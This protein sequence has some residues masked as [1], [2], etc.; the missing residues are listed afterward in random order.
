MHRP[1]NETTPEIDGTAPVGPAERSS[2][3][4]LLVELDRR[5]ASYTAAADAREIASQVFSAAYALNDAIRRAEKCGMATEEIRSHVAHTWRIVGSSSF[6]R[7]IQEWPRGY[8]GD[9]EAVNAIVDRRE[10]APEH[11]VAGVIGRYFL[12]CPLTQQ[13]REKLVVQALRAVE[14]CRRKAGARILSLGCGPS[15]DLDSIQHDLSESQAEIV[16]VDFDRDALEESRRRLRGLRRQPTLIHASV[17]R[18]PTLLGDLT[19][20]SGFD[21][22]YAGGLFDYLSA[23]VIAILLDK[24]TGRLLAPE[25]SFLFTN[26][27]AENPYRPWIETIANWRL[28]ERTERDLVSLIAQ[29]QLGCSG[30]RIA[31]DPTGLTWIAEVFR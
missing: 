19:G 24:I 30:H 21:L 16:L 29:A 3:I 15:R 13:H 23:A 26:I 10:L 18:L 2:A 28:I 6:G 5:F 8:Q 9:F 1:P 4:E 22:V 11:T 14:C 20:G 31:K 7:H 25:G 27:A 17:R 12:N